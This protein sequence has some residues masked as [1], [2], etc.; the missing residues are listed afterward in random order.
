MYRSPNG[1]DTHNNKS[2]FNRP[3]V[4][5]INEK[6]WSYLQ[7]HYQMSPREL[8]VA[9]LVC[10]G[11]KDTEMAQYLNINDGTVKTH[12]RNV[13]RRVRVRNKITLLLRLVNDA[14]KFSA[15][16]GTTPPVPPIVN[17]R[18]PGERASTF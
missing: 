18:K 1:K 4:T 14:A 3:A 7:E 8:Q 5:L 9:K 10:W 12:L 15:K 13:C 17:V 2:L 6:Q 11:F 16:S